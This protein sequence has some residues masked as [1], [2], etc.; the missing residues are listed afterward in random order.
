MNFNIFI[1][2]TFM[3][4]QTL[5]NIALECDCVVLYCYAL[6]Y[7]DYFRTC[8]QHEVSTP[9]RF[10]NSLGHWAL[11]WGFRRTIKLITSRYCQQLL[12]S[13]I[14]DCTSL[15]SIIITLQYSHNMEGWILI[16]GSLRA[17]NL[18][19]YSSWAQ[20]CRR[21]FSHISMMRVLCVTIASPCIPSICLCVETTIRDGHWLFERVYKVYRFSVHRSTKYVKC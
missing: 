21:P 14:V 2:K 5:E 6:V 4:N 17:Y 7:R 12:G 10:L 18:Y 20:G 11:G 16:Q 3:N 8:S 13:A 9:S 1:Y 15:Y 19:I